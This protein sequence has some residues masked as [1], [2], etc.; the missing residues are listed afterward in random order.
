[1]S[2]NKCL[3][4]ILAGG[5]GSRLKAL[6]K[7]VAKPA[8][9]FGGKYRIIDFPLSNCAN[10]G[11]DTV[12]VATQYRP[13]ELHTY[14]G[15]GNAWDLDKRDG[16]VFILPPYAREK[17]ADWYKGTADA[18]Y[19]NLNFIDTVDPDYVLILSGDHIYTM[20]YAKMLAAH[21]ER[22]AD[23]TIG[24]FEVPWDEAPRFGIMNTDTSDGRI[25]EFEEKPAQPK[26]NLA[27]MGIYIF[28]RDLLD[29]Y[30]KEDAEEEGSEHDFGKN[31]IP[32]MLKDNRRMYSYAFEGYWKD[33]GTIE[34]LWQAN[35]DFLEDEP[36][37]E[38]SSDWRIYSSNPS[39]PPQYIGPDAK[40]SRSMINEGSMILGEV[41]H[42]MLSS[43]V[44]VGKNAKV[45][46][47]VIL[48]FAVIEDGAVVDHAIVAQHS[49]IK[50]G[51][52]VEGK[53]GEI[54]VIPE[55]TVVEA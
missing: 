42:S 20:D 44:K 46:N 51:A 22:N 10:S 31:I 48:P 34:S 1:M 45:T 40:V 43:G 33:V 38:L 32:K 21:K 28:S 17:G 24:V 7:N 19:Q 29:K 27:S 3:A 4:M 49:V 6:T 39:L 8:V 50:A 54:L 23:A 30:L 41:E 12:G 25:I 15:T 53:P 18:I 5:Q 13:L 47:S 37:F 55:K 35:M 11:I 2:K 9:P 16:G 14:L 26:S 36:P 52:K